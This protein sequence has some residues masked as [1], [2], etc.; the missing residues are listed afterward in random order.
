VGKEVLSIFD[1]M[2]SL[3]L[4]RINDLARTAAALLLGVYIGSKTTIAS[5]LLKF[6]RTV[7]WKRK[8][9]RM[10]EDHDTIPVERAFALAKAIIRAHLGDFET[11]FSIN[12]QLQKLVELGLLEIR[13]DVYGDPRVKCLAT[14][15]E[16]SA[17]ATAYHINIHEYVPCDNH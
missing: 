1:T 13:G 9:H 2:R 11:D 10:L 12:L 7:Q 3:Q 4:S 16:I 15:H 6:A 8:E 17:V 5:D 14:E